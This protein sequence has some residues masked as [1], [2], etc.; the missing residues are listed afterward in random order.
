MTAIPEL[1]DLHPVLNRMFQ[2]L[3]RDD[4]YSGSGPRW[5]AFLSAD[6]YIEFRIKDGDSGVLH[7]DAT[8]LNGDDPLPT[9]GEVL[10]WV[11]QQPVPALGVISLISDESDDGSVEFRPLLTFEVGLDSIVSEF[12]DQNVLPFADAWERRVVA[13]VS[14]I[15]AGAYRLDPVRIEPQNAWLL[16]GDEA[17]YPTA[18]ALAEMWSKGKGGIFGTDWTA[19]KN[20]DLGD[21]VLCYFI[22]P[23]RAACFV[24]RLASRPFWETD[25]EVNAIKTVG[26]HQWWVYLTPLVE[27]EPIP[28]STLQAAQDGQLLLKGRSGHY[29]HPEAVGRLTFKAKNP[30]QQAELDRVAQ[31]PVGDTALP[32]ISTI[33]FEQWVQINPALLPLEAKVSEYIVQPLQKL[34]NLPS[35][36]LRALP[37][38]VLRPQHRVS[39]GV[40]DFVVSAA[41]VL[42]AAV[43]VKLAVERPGSGIWSESPDFQQLRRYMDVLN[44]PGILID[45]HSIL[46]V[47]VGADSPHAEIIRAKATPEDLGLIREILFYAAHD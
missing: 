47:K 33:T 8:L 20:G 2:E 25:I 35:P 11:D 15:E 3:T 19:P 32:E 41:E 27:I 36:Q 23:K 13:Q 39:K 26:R 34:L 5:V 24:G 37:D 45:A 17:S 9:E 22:A 21:L 38:L 16:M 18:E 14:P 43:E 40:V 30:D 6:A 10:D 44:L 29:L 1:P 12:I 7:I 31:K 28:F 4:G 46:L 42:L